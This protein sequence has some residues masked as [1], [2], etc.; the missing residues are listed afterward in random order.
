MHELESRCRRLEKEKALLQKELAELQKKV[1][2]RSMITN[3]TKMETNGQEGQ[4][5]GQ[6]EMKSKRKEQQKPK[7]QQQQHQPP[8]VQRQPNRPK[9]RPQQPKKPGSKTDAA[10]LAGKKD[11]Q[12]YT[13]VYKPG[14]TV[15]AGDSLLKNLKGWMMARDG[16]ININS[17]P[18]AT[19]QDMHHYLKP[20]LARKPD[21][22]ILHCGTNNLMNSLDAEDIAN[23]II[24]LGRNIADTGTR[25]SISMLIS[26]RDELESMVR[27]VNN[28]LAKNMPPEISTIDNSNISNNY[29]LNSS[30]LHLNRKGDGALALNIIKHVLKGTSC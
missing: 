28:C 22:V 30:G 21:H 25:C 19:T 7:K 11:K 8:N 6:V 15:V 26:R 17:F 13:A 16:K 2:N 10:G 14:T 18:G 5:P 1:N 27:N 29:H 4:A 3:R 12:G 20:L 24:E 23:K 9:A